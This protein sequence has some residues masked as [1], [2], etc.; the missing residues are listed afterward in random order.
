MKLPRMRTVFNRLGQDPAEPPIEVD[1]KHLYDNEF[2]EP[3]RKFL[4]QG[5][6]PP[7]SKPY[8]PI[9]RGFKPPG[10]CKAQETAPK[11]RRETMDT[12]NLRAWAKQVENLSCTEGRLFLDEHGVVIALIAK[13]KRRGVVC[14]ARYC[15]PYI[16]IE[17]AT[18]DIVAQRIHDTH[19]HLMEQL[20]QKGEKP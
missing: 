18:V 10:S 8:C 16:E 17:E 1:C 4:K 20:R 14:D 11:V 19:M 2:C 15:V 6:F 7:W 13:V 12:Q 9:A 5:G 3:K